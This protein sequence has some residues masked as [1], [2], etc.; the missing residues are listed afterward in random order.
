MF[1]YN[2]KICSFIMFSEGKMWQIVA[3]LTAK[4]KK[5]I[6]N[7]TVDHFYYLCKAGFL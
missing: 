5:Y 3:S 6:K 4:Y 2:S 1:L 7:L